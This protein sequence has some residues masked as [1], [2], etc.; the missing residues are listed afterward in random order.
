[1]STDIRLASSP[2]V[3]DRRALLMVRHGLG[4]HTAL[5]A[6]VL[7]HRYPSL[8]VSSGLR[9]AGRNRQVGGVPNSFHLSG[10]AVD[11]VGPLST[12]RA[13]AST[14]LAQRVSPGCTGPEEVLIE[15]AGESG[16]H[17][18]VAW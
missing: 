1:M 7:L 10:R 13:A 4:A 12:L 11:L 17:L 14:A 3:R 18:H 16:Q 5:H 6:S 9:T 8:R 2:T 15:L